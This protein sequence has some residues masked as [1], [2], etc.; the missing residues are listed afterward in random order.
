LHNKLKL[1]LLIGWED[2]NKLFLVAIQQHEPRSLLR[3]LQ[4]FPQFARFRVVKVDNA[5]AEHSLFGLT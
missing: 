5:F 1:A 4:G 2:G 3:V